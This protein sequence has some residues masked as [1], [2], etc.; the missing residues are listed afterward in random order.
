MLDTRRP[1]LAARRWLPLAALAALTLLPAVRAQQPPEKGDKQATPSL[2]TEQERKVIAEA[3]SGSEVIKNLT[4]LC[5]QIGPRLTGSAALKKAN[6]WAA[7]RM[8][9]YGLANV[10]Q[11]A[12]SMPEGW[13]RG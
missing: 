6:E 11:E 5:D 2:A 10:H 1:P 7:G 13:K 12:W 4:Q 3:K 8:K 9:A